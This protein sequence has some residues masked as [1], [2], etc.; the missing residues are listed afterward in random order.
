MDILVLGVTLIICNIIWAFFNKNT[1]N[2]NSETTTF[3]F[4]KFKMLEEHSKS[5]TNLQQSADRKVSEFNLVK[6]LNDERFFKQ[7][8]ELYLSGIDLKRITIEQIKTLDPILH[9]ELITLSNENL[10]KIEEYLE[11]V[12]YNTNK[13]LNVVNYTTLSTRYKFSKN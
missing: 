13:D 8:N 7:V 10:K 4:E 11:S 1:Q 2:T 12:K 3:L 6:Q 9:S 5:V